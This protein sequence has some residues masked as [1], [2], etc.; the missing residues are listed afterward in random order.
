ME[1]HV[2][3]TLAWA[4]NRLGRAARK[5]TEQEFRRLEA[6][7]QPVVNAPADGFDEL[8]AETTALRD[9]SLIHI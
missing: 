8:V 4:T 6:A 3:S 1:Q 5:V 2:Q 9:L 7:L